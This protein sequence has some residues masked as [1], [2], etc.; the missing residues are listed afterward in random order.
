MFWILLI[1]GYLC[2]I[3]GFFTAALVSAAKEGDE[4]EFLEDDDDEK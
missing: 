2:F 4:A 1:V 3:A